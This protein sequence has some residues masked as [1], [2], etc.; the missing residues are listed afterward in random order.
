MKN[1]FQALT[2][3]YMKGGDEV[4]V[5]VTPNVLDCVNFLLEAD[6]IQYHRNDKTKVRMIELL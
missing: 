5:N 3:A 2:S 6:I 1:C 4:Y